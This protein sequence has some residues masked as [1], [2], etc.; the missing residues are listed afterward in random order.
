MLGLLG[1]SQRMLKLLGVNPTDA[2]Y[3]LL[4][5]PRR[6][7]GTVRRVLVDVA[8]NLTPFTAGFVLLNLPAQHLAFTIAG[9]IL[10]LIGFAV[11]AWTGLRRRR[12]DPTRELVVS[13]DTSSVATPES[14]AAFATAGGT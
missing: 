13:T 5:S 1:T 12:H 8:I 11:L 4:A 3:R 10:W 6:L 9:G 7:R 2:P 14:I